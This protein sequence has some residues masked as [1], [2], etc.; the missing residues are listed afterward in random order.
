MMAQANPELKQDFDF[1]FAITIHTLA[2]SVCN[3]VHI[4]VLEQAS[5]LLHKN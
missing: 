3:M 2:L 5:Q 4:C 1:L